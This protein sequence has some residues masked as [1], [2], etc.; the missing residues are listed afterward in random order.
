MIFLCQFSLLFIF[1]INSSPLNNDFL[2][3]SMN[4]SLTLSSVFVSALF[5][6]VPNKSFLN[7]F[8]MIS[9]VS[10]SILLM[11]KLL[12][13]LKGFCLLVF[14]QEVPVLW[15]SRIDLSRDSG[16]FLG[17]IPD[18]LGVRTI[19]HIIRVTNL[20]LHV[21]V[22]HIFILIILLLMKIRKSLVTRLFVL[23]THLIP[24]IDVSVST[25][26]TIYL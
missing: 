14:A 19:C 2:G 5:L 21:P 1:L 7:K 9:Y 3:L 23:I 10:L 24:N 4:N 13:L 18:F 22:K 15:F 8:T 17:G 16:N 11:F 6:R 26:K 12:T 20:I 25:T